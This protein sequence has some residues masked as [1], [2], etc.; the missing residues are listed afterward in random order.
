MAAAHVAGLSLYFM[1]TYGPHTP[2]RMRGRI[3]GWATRGLVKNLGEGSP[4]LIAFNGVVVDDEQ[5]SRSF[6]ENTEIATSW[7]SKAASS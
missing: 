7:A 2:R 3:T 1:Q 4:N 6:A 5:M